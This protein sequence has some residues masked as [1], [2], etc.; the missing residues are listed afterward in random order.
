M[1]IT[2]GILAYEAQAPLK[3]VA[4]H[5]ATILYLLIIF[6]VFKKVVAQKD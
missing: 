1:P 6:F 3:V 2:D 5:V 4:K